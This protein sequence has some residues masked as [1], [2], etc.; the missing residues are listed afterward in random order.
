MEISLAL[1]SQLFIIS[2]VQRGKKANDVMNWPGCFN[3]FIRIV[4]P[5]DLSCAFTSSTLID[6]E[7]LRIIMS[8]KEMKRNF[9]F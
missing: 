3:G 6:A 1:D 2:C 4:K 8:I 9:P 7:M 5:I